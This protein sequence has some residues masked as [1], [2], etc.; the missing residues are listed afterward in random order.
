MVEENLF[1]EG[2]SKEQG[3][4]C[5]QAAQRVVAK[6]AEQLE[7][8]PR[9]VARRFKRGR[10]KDAEVTTAVLTHSAAEAV[11]IDPENLRAILQ[12]ILE[13]IK[14]LLPLFI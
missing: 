5:V 2:I 9:Q 8:R 13:F 4:L 7:M 1:K 10:Q 3:E 12:V 14:A 6:V 11:A